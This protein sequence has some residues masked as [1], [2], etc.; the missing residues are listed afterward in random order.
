MPS[1]IL[2]EIA[3]PSHKIPQGL[4]SQR[5]PIQS[6]LGF[7]L[8]QGS[9]GFQGLNQVPYAHIHCQ[10][11]ICQV[12]RLTTSNCTVKNPKC[13]TVNC[14]GKMVIW[15]SKVKIFGQH[16]ILKPQSLFYQFLIMIPQA[17]LKKSQDAKVSIFGQLKSQLQI[18]QGI[19]S[20]WFI[21][22]IPS[23]AHF[24]GDDISYNSSSHSKSKKCSHKKLSISTL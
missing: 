17:W 13:S 6:K 20:S 24:E 23:N 8:L 14:R 3:K 4:H 19:T 16:I 12:S 7:W 2:Q 18:D 1:H 10:A 22:K 9:W 21:R 11:F 5:S 15:Q